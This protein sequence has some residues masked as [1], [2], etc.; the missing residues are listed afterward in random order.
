MSESTRRGPGGL[1]QRRLAAAILALLLPLTGGAD[2]LPALGGHTGGEITAAQEREIGQRFLAQA[3]RQ[4]SFVRDKEVLGYI[5]TL[6]HRVAAQTDFHAY[7]FHFYVVKDSRLNAFAVPGGHIFIHSGLVEAAQTPDEVAGV[8]AHEVAHI[9]QRHMARQ[10]S[11]SKQTQLSSLLLVMAGILAGMQGEGE[12]AEALV[13]GAGAY[14][15]QEMLAYSRAHEHEADRLG[16][17]YLAAAG[18][19]PEGLP[20]FLE[21]LRAWSQLQGAAPAPYLSTHPLT[22]SRIADARSRARQ[23]GEGD[24]T[25]PL[26]DDTFRRIQARL[27]ARTADSPQAAYA[28]LRQRAEDHPKDAA[29]RYGLALAAQR[30]GRSEEA[31]SLLRG[32]VGAHPE[33]VVYRQTLGEVLIQAARPG[34]AAAT[35]EAALERRPDDPELRQQLGQARLEE[36]KTGEAKRILLELTR[37]YPESASAH[38]AL[39]EAYSRLDRPIEAHRQEAEAR[40]LAGQPAEALEQLRLAERLAKEQDSPQLPR[41]RARI[42]ELEP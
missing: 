33:E 11:A 9:T 31:I 19:D 21:R 14:S 5:R 32:L 7:P 30:S 13:I 8:L 38:S 29:A 6:G 24:G 42:Q 20:G 22:G 15:Q 10:V 37:D 17:R 25:T 41:I 40:W 34:K 23:L 35:F 2:T 3:R 36:G 28:E 18:F 39:A 26:G 1:L 16:I 27:Q 12:A 4:L